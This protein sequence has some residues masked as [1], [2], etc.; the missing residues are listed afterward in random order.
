MTRHARIEIVPS[1]VVYID[2]DG[3]EW[4]Q[5]TPSTTPHFLRLVSANGATLAHSENYATRFNARRAAV[6]WLRAMDDVLSQAYGGEEWV[7]EVES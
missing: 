7:R 4:P 1:P 3:N 5:L 2:E 6:S